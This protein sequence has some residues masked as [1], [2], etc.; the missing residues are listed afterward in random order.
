LPFDLFVKISTGWHDSSALRLLK[1]YRRAPIANKT[2]GTS[3]KLKTAIKT[4][5]AIMNIMP[6]FMQAL[7]FFV[8]LP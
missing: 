8:E 6:P 2:K 3:K 5:M 4:N 7:A 1:Q